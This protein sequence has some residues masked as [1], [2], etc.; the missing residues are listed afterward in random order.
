MKVEESLNVTFDETP[1]PPKTSPLEDDDLVEEQ[2]IE[3]MAQ[4]KRT[5]RASPATT[6]TTTPI[7]NTQLKALID[8]GIINALAAHDADRSM[9]GDDSHNS[10]MGVRRN[11]T[12]GHDVTYEMTWT[13]LKKKMTDKYCLRSEIKKLENVAQAYAAGTGERKE[14]AGTLP[15]CNK[16][17]SLAA[18]NNQRNLTCYECRNPRNYMSDCPK[19]KNQNHRNQAEGTGARGL[20]HALGGGE[21]D[22]DLNDMEDDIS[23]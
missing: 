11:E 20:V 13:D 21:T 12:V 23:A 15:F 17:K 14:Y 6:T 18:T 16:R 5:T 8:Q 22:Q 7:T 4:K 9:N 10:G 19:L 2:A 3:E 1:P